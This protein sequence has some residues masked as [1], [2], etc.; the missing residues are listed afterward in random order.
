VLQ[1]CIA[2]NNGW[3]NTDPGRF[4][5]SGFYVH[6]N[7]NL[8]GCSAVHNRN[9]GFYV[10]GG[11]RI[12]FDRCS[13][14]GS[15][16]GWLVVKSSHDVV[17]ENCRSDEARVWALWAAYA[18]RITLTDFTQVGAG[19]ARGVQSILGWYKDDGR[20]GRPV[21]DSSFEIAASGPAGTAPITREGAGNHYAITAVPA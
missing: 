1:N 10:Q 14:Q 9:A 19:S 8:T 2:K 18:S 11:E 4:F 5:M 3:R 15:T 21:T 16:Y 13:D 6:R 20:Y 7:A 12:R 17:L